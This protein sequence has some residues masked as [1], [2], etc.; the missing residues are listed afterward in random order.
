MVIVAAANWRTE[1]NR[2]S[3]CV[4]RSVHS[5]YVQGTT[6]ANVCRYIA[7]MCVSVHKKLCTLASF[8]CSWHTTLC[9]YRIYSMC[10]RR[11][12]LAC[13][14]GA[15]EYIRLKKNNPMWDSVVRWCMCHAFKS[16]I[17]GW[18]CVGVRACVCAY[19]LCKTSTRRCIGE[20]D[21]YGTPT[22]FFKYGKSD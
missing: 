6:I 20:C 4:F 18:G 5:S 19:G 21:V 3:E 10:S 14:W 1:T 2:R 9:I 15:C 12:T 11:D 17:Y 13:W 7:P 8:C 16:R 22:I